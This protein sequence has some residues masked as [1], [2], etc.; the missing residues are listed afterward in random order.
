M[1]SPL[2][3]HMRFLTKRF[4]TPAFQCAFFGL[5]VVAFSLLVRV[6]QVQ[7]DTPSGSS[8]CHLNFEV[9]GT[10][11]QIL[12]GYSRLRGQG[13]ITCVDAVGKTTSTNMKVTVGTPLLF[14]RISFAP[15]L[16]VRGAA[17]QIRI[18]KGGP[19]VIFG[20]YMT[21]DIRF[22]FGEGIFFDRFIPI[23]AQYCA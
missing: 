10:D 17:D 9:K 18:L 6:E 7:A 16:T 4:L 1:Q 15:S 3:F 14:P 23:S 11:I 22:A 2:V 5:L 12:L 19:E 13:V 21:L 8:I 20:K